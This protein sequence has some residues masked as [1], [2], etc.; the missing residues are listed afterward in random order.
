M[1]FWLVSSSFYDQ[2]ICDGWSLAAMFNEVTSNKTKNN[3]NKKTK[4]KNPTLGPGGRKIEVL[5]SVNHRATIT[6]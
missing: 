2:K 1:C 3:N 4:P 5:I 6:A